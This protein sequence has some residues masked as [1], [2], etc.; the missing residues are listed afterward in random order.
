[1]ISGNSEEERNRRQ[2]KL[3]TK[4]EIERLKIGGVDIHE[5][6][7]EENASKK[8]LYKDRDGNIYVKPK[9]GMSPGEPTD[10]NINDF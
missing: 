2:D 7:N 1:M 4:Q 9:C 8:D 3:L 5:I 10:L 6:K